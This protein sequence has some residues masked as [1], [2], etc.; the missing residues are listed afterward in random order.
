MIQ[1]VV[2][3]IIKSLDVKSFN[4]TVATSFSDGDIALLLSGQEISFKRTLQKVCIRE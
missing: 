3:A 2:T 4:K 1:L